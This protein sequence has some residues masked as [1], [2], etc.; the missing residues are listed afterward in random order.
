MDTEDFALDIKVQRRKAGLSQRDVAHLLGVHPSK[1]SLMEAGKTLPSLR[2]IAH[3]S[4][5]YGKSFEEFFYAFVSKARRTLKT[6]LSTMP[7]APKRWLGRFN[8][9]YT[10]D[11]I[12]ERLAATD[13]DHEPS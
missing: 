13:S 5:V 4:L 3:L 9:Q 7:A 6:R 11:K 1:V 8:R 12:A 2:D 10:V